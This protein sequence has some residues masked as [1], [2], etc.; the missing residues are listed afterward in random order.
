MNPM[1]MQHCPPKLQLNDYVLGKLSDADR[2]P[3]FNHVDTC[4]VCQAAVQQLNERQSDSLVDHL[5]GG[6]PADDIDGAS[7]LDLCG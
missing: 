2:E 7:A 4:S 6:M 1:P 3:V 5:V